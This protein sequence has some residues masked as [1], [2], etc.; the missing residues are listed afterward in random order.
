MGASWNDRYMNATAVMYP[1]N[2][3][4]STAI[5]FGADD[6]NNK[7]IQSAHAGGAFVVLTDGHVKFLSDAMDLI[8]LKNLCSRND[9]N[10]V[11][12]Y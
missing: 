2:F 3:K 12:E 10:L 5:G 11:G 6:G 8:T 7:G 9:G 4:D 1:I